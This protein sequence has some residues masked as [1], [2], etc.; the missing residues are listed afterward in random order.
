MSTY[1]HFSKKHRKKETQPKTTSESDWFSP[2]VKQLREAGYRR[3]RLQDLRLTIKGVDYTAHELVSSE[4]FLFAAFSGL[5]LTERS[6][7]QEDGEG[8]SAP[9]FDDYSKWKEWRLGKLRVALREGIYLPKPSRQKPI[10]KL[11]FPEE[12]GVEHLEQLWSKEVSAIE[13]GPRTLT[14]DDV[15]HRGVAGSLQ[16]LLSIYLS[17]RWRNCVVG[18]RAG[19]GVPEILATLDHA[20]VKTGLTGVLAADIKGFYDQIPFKRC[21][22][23]LDNQV[24][25]KSSPLLKRIVDCTL[26]T[27]R[28]GP[29]GVPQGNPLSPLLANLFGTETVDKAGVLWG[30]YMRYVDDITLLVKTADEAVDAYSA[31]SSSF[32]GAPLKLHPDKTWFHDLRTGQGFKLGN[33]T[34]RMPAPFVY[35]G[36]EIRLAESGGLAF[37]LTN[38]AIRRLFE[39]QRDTWYSHRGRD[40]KKREWFLECF[41][42]SR[43]RLAGWLE[44]Y[45]FC[46]WTAEQEAAVGLIARLSYMNDASLR[47]FLP[48]VLRECHDTQEDRDGVIQ[49]VADLC[50]MKRKKGAAYT[51]EDLTVWGD[52][53]LKRV[54]DRSRA[55]LDKARTHPAD[56]AYKRGGGGPRWFHTK[57]G[58]RLK[59]KGMVATDPHDLVPAP[60]ADLLVQRGSFVP[61]GAEDRF[62]NATEQVSYGY[63]R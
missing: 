34:V 18:F 7:L 50:G 36:V 22:E 2:A 60:L 51:L 9:V 56:L 23:L 59:E 39:A 13:E 41:K 27:R 24:G 47:A 46:E 44:A 42:R 15:E 54:R 16:L 21:L 63:D 28:E 31:L 30:P 55:R 45:G 61:G 1:G 62:R 11:K 3:T 49:A 40:E 52:S 14:I 57:K 43:Y 8:S 32:K 58:G 37:H 10:P 33:P 38:K 17:S 26:S 5:T 25:Y 35:L 12:I 19:I 4:P 48:E 6:L 53:G 20:I 29:L